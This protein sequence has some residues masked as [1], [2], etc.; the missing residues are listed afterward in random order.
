[1][2]IV[3]PAAS[4]APALVLGWPAGWCSPEKKAAEDV[5]G[6]AQVN[7]RSYCRAD[8][9]GCRVTRRPGAHPVRDGHGADGDLGAS[10]LELN[11]IDPQRL[12]KNLLD[13]KICRPIGSWCF[14]SGTT[15]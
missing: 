4:P 10:A 1:M 5:Y 9:L 15:A 8:R 14:P 3:D 7:R 12:P 11:P 13:K 6:K 2:A